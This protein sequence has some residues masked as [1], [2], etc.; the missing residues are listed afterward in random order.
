[1]SY[2]RY[3]MLIVPQDFPGTC[4]RCEVYRL[5]LFRCPSK[6]SVAE[7]YYFFPTWTLAQV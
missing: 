6:A 1:M 2:Q 7:H 4:T 5:K 3:P